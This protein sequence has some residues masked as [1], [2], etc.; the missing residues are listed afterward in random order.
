MKYSRILIRSMA[1]SQRKSG[2]AVVVV[3]RP[4]CRIGTAGGIGPFYIC[5]GGSLEGRQ[6]R[7]TRASHSG[8]PTGHRA[9]TG[10]TPTGTYGN[11]EVQPLPAD[12]NA[13]CEGQIQVC[14][15]WPS[16]TYNSNP[17]RGPWAL[18]HLC[19]TVSTA[20]EGINQL[21]RIPYRYSGN[22]DGLLLWKNGLDATWW[23]GGEVWEVLQ[24][25]GGCNTHL[26]LGGSL[27][28][29]HRPVSSVR[30]GRT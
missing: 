5:D 11:L 21:C 30:A 19:N 2:R 28:N 29:P 23:N 25:V 24:V 15:G 20:S 16:A 26:P 3:D 27:C 18:M 13:A 4:Q 22:Y 8:H 14:Q 17:A 6:G 10:Q 9:L 1:K 7:C 12:F